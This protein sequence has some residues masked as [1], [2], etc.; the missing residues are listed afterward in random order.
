M[1]INLYKKNLKKL[2]KANAYYPS[3]EH[4]ACGVGLVTSIEGK[5]SRK[6][7]EFGIQALKAVWHRG[8]VD[9]D[10]KTGD[11]AGILLQ[12]SHEFF[13]RAAGDI[14]IELPEV[15]GYG[16]GMVFLPQDEPLR[17]QCEGLFESIIREEGVRFLGW[18]DVPIKPEY[19]G[20][21]AKQTLPC[22]RQFFIARDILNEAQFERKPVSYTHLTL[23]TKRIV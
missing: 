7:V 11:G 16:V 23:P 13:R 15:G 14:G 9:A 2:T 8:A 4:D 3:L 20:D 22:I 17:R 19:I 10:G 5:Q 21:Q 18:R 6:I 1:T 12:I